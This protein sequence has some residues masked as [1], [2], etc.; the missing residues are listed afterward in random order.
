M[1]PTGGARPGPLDGDTPQAEELAA[2]LRRLTRGV[3]LRELENRFPYGRTQWSAFLKGR[4]LLP[5]W[6]L[7][8]LVTALVPD[9]RLRQ[10]HLRRG[11]ALLQAAEKA[12]QARQPLDEAVSSSASSQELQLRLDEARKGQLQAQE[13]L[14]ATTQIIQ[15]LLSMVASLRERCAL[16]ETERDRAQAQLRTST[17]SEIRQELAASQQ[18]LTQ[19][20]ERL[21]TARR[22]RQ[23]AEELRI[24]AQQQAEAYRRAQQTSQQAQEQ[25]TPQEGDSASSD[26]GEPASFTVTGL[27]D[28]Q[29]YDDL[30]QVTDQQLETHHS[31]LSGLRE[32]LGLTETTPPESEKTL[33][34]EVVRTPQRTTRTTPQP[35][36][37]PPAHRPHA[38]RTTPD[39]PATSKNAST[40]GPG[41]RTRG[42]VVLAG[43]IALV[44]AVAVPSTVIWMNRHSGK[45]PAAGPETEPSSSPTS[46]RPSPR[47]T[48]TN[49]EPSSLPA[50]SDDQVADIGDT[51]I[52]TPAIMKLPDCNDSPAGS[53]KPFIQPD[54][55]PL[56]LG[57]KAAIRMTLTRVTGDACRYDLGSNTA[58]FRVSARPEGIPWDGKSNKYLSWSTAMC[59]PSDAPSRWA[60]LDA[61]SP[62]TITYHWDFRLAK[63]DVAYRDWAVV[64]SRANCH[65]ATFDKP[66]YKY[67]F[68][69]KTPSLPGNDSVGDWLNVKP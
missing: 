27:P 64:R 52:N 7:Q 17:V 32:Q 3:T 24:A 20:E 10:Q 35:A 55:A 57:G 19:T 8:D 21:A 56:R 1:T 66:G 41:K 50:N 38:P 2:W 47:G 9:P 45:P 14:L 69:I 58:P 61:A 22:E 13:T 23:E 18:R 16:L 25:E 30:L 63:D 44:L 4:K 48:S 65:A 34:G 59:S 46:T 62:L 6:L 54:P 31:Q 15:M 26:G 42:P 29:I 37:E 53:V 33:I 5:S 36:A 43:A 40:S 39:N 28:L 67:Y 51:V 68:V 12:V 11:Q 60:R 49:E